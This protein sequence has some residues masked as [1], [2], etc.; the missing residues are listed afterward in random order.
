MAQANSVYVLRLVSPIGEP[1]R[2]YV[3]SSVD[4]ESRIAAHRAGCGAAYTKR[5]PVDSIISISAGDRFDEDATVRRLMAEH[6]IAYVRGGAYSRIKLTKSD[7]ATLRRELHAAVD[8]CLRCGSR[9][10][11]VASCPQR[12][13]AARAPTGKNRKAQAVTCARCGRAS[14]TESDCYATTDAQ[15]MD[16]GR[17]RMAHAVGCVCCVVSADVIDYDKLRR[18]GWTLTKGFAKPDLVLPLPP[19]EPPPPPSEPPPPP[20]EPPPIDASLLEKSRHVRSFMA[21]YQEKMGLGSA[22]HHRIYDRVERT[23][24][25]DMPSQ[26]TIDMIE[27]LY[28]K[29]IQFVNKYG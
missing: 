1:P 23:I 10:H 8:A 6:G 28:C 22:P 7:M 29:S 9:D 5:Y 2:F 21:K 24:A 18:Q 13:P 17:R 14:H 11:S 25:G 3:G 20:S 12:A 16:I 15:G 27:K 19:S 4:P 26:T